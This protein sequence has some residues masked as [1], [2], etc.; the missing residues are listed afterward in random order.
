MVKCHH[1]KQR[2]Q[3]Q[4]AKVGCIA[5][6]YFLTV[7][8]LNHCH[9]VSSPTERE[10]CQIVYL[11]KCKAHW[12]HYDT[13]PFVFPSFSSFSLFFTLDA[14]SPHFL[15]K[16]HLNIWVVLTSA[17]EKNKSGNKAT[18]WPRINGK[19]V[20]FATSSCLK[21]FRVAEVCFSQG[22]VNQKCVCPSL[23]VKCWT[24]VFVILAVQQGSHGSLKV[25][26]F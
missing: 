23:L 3:Q 4:R 22:S 2:K 26:E 19:E 21:S 11:F 24:R 20:S 6:L 7:L 17:S 8:L 10:V 5:I 1:G 25:C 13:F 16:K 18:T 12:R 9:A 15:L 14:F